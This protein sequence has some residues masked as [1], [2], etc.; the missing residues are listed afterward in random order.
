MEVRISIDTKQHGPPSTPTSAADPG[1][2]VVVSI[3]HIFMAC[4]LGA[5]LEPIC[6]LLAHNIY[7]LYGH[8]LFAS[9]G[10]TVAIPCLGGVGGAEHLGPGLP[11]KA[12]CHYSLKDQSAVVRQG[13]GTLLFT[14]PLLRAELGF[15][16]SSPPYRE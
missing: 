1:C 8:Y 11:A 12:L 13:A 14:I 7:R 5:E 10:W 9:D 16:L 4:M 3:I 2:P 6:L 15:L